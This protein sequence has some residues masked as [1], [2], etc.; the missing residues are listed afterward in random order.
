VQPAAAARAAEGFDAV[1]EQHQRNR[2]RQGEADPCRERA[3]VAG[4]RQAD[5]NSNLAAGR[6]REELA[7]RN[8]IGV[9]LFPEPPASHDELVV[10]VAE[11]RDRTA[12][13]GEP[14]PKEDE[15]NLPNG[16]ALHR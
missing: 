14:E 4:A 15:Q 12:E 8:E 5:G 11:M 16:T 13:T 10:K 3:E 7:K 6:P 2:G 1:G 9:G